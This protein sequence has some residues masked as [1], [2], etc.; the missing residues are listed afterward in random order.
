MRFYEF[1]FIDNTTKAYEQLV[2]C[3]MFYF[4]GVFKVQ[5]DFKMALK[6]ASLVEILRGRVQCNEI[7]YLAVCGG[8]M[9]AGFSSYYT[10]QMLLTVLDGAEVVYSANLSLI[11][12]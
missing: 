8:A 1:T 3:D 5:D 10:V 7:C 9:L 4:A 6:N 11:H 12:I 2:S